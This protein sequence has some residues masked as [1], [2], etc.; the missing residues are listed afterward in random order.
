[1][2]VPADELVITG[3]GTI[4]PVGGDAPATMTALL[5]GTSGVRLLPEPERAATPVYLHAPVDDAGLTRISKVELK[6]FDR[7][8]H[9]GLQAA[10]EA[11]EDA[12]AP[13]VDGARLAVLMAT[14]VGG[15]L[16]IY[17][18]RDRFVKK[19]YR[20]VPAHSVPALMANA[21]SALIATELGAHAGALSFGSACAS[22]ASALA[23]AQYLFMD[24]DV[25]VAIVG[26]TEAV[27]DPATLSA[28]AALRALSVRH[29]D[30][31]A[32]SRPFDRDRDGFVLGEGAAAFVIERRRHAVARGA[33][34][35]GRLLGVG[36]T[37][38]GSHIVAPEATGRWCAEAISR[39]L[40]RSGLLPSDITFISAHATATVM[41]DL[42]EW[43]AFQSAF[44][45][46][47]PDISVTAVK[48][49]IGHLMGAS[50]SVAMA[51]AVMSLHEKLVPP[52]QNLETL[53][54]DIELDIVSGK[55]RSISKGYALINSS[56]FGGQN[57]AVVVGSE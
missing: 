34:I 42:A 7:S 9:L 29:Q 32:A 53:D 27:I 38:D 41:G 4:S 52:T 12:K 2:T 46:A 6:R 15:L 22:G 17:A 10:R 48:S 5:A 45:A 43:R 57:V 39:A 55:P 50:G 47:L 40:R 23:H 13:A 30:P 21:T 24:D 3:I 20:G 18:E 44:G 54:P 28:F 56:G 16:T 37:C 36:S 19:G 49:G 14:G 31:V 1:V 26:G 8:V 33:R 25:D 11:W 51:L 35:W